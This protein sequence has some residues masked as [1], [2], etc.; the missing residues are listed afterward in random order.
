[1]KCGRPGPDEFVIPAERIHNGFECGWSAN[2]FAKWARRVLTPAAEAIGRPDLTA[3]VLRHSFASLLAH[4]GRSAVYIAAQLGHSPDL[5]VRVY[6][7][8]ISEFRAP[9]LGAEDAIRQAGSSA[10]QARLS[11]TEIR[12]RGDSDPP[13]G[14]PVSVC[15]MKVP[16]L[17]KRHQSG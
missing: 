9:R 6:Q 14:V 5:S 7:H 12:A 2:G 4:E 10:S 17:A 1:M 11:G 13:T 15:P 3:Y 16:R 8:V